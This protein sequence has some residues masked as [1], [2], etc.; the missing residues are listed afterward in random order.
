M[1]GQPL[2]E[3]K[4]NE[5]AERFRLMAAR[6]DLNADTSRFGGAV[7]IIPPEG[8]GEAIEILML[9]STANAAQFFGQ[10]QT[11]ITIQV[12]E[13]QERA[14]IAQGFGGR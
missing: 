5:A 10:I 11:R 8:G 3:P 14:R 13:A 4:K 1:D 7:V 2:I 12:Q 6:I 9:D